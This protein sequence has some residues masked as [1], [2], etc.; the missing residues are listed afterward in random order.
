MTKLLDAKELLKTLISFQSLS[1]QEKEIADFLFEYCKQ[2]SNVHIERIG[3]NILLR[4]KGLTDKELLFNTHL[5]VVPAS[6]N[7]AYPAF[8]AF[9]EQDRIY[10]RGSTDA[11]GSLAAMLTALTELTLEKK[12]P[13]FSLLIAFTVCE[14]SY[15]D[16]NGAVALKQKGYF[17][18]CVAGIVGEPTSLAPCIA[19]KG[20]LLL[21]LVLKGKSGHAARIKPEDNLLYTLPS[22]LN[23]LKDVHYPIENNWVG[24]V[25]ITPTKISGGTANNM[26]PEEIRITLDI[27]TIPESTTDA[28]CTLIQNK[29]PEATI[30]IRSDRFKSVS[31][32]SNSSIAQCCRI[33]SQKE[34]FGSPTCSDWAFLEHLK[35]IKIGPGHSEQSHTANEYIEIGQLLKGVELYKSIMLKFESEIDI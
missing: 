29:I 12:K 25:K 13:K 3:N 33:E 22:V 26:A 8:N 24:P 21:D 27:R 18:H 15:G 31:T 20:I 28:I 9:E 6:P 32:D 34:Y 2:L 17:D 23:R 30:Q 11:K 5:D 14:E 19:Q 10:G 1:T 16:F 35:M 4:Y 7:H